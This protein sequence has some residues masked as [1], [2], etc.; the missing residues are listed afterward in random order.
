[1]RFIEI[2]DAGQS[3]LLAAALAAGFGS[4]S[5]CHRAFSAAFG[6]TPRAFF[7]TPIRS[8]MADTFEPFGAGASD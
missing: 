2:V 6:C 5:Q 4:Y 7:G 8:E 1:L 3:T